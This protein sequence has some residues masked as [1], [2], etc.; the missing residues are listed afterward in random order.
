MENREQPFALTRPPP[1]LP[2]SQW[3]VSALKVPN[4]I[5]TPICPPALYKRPHQPLI[6]ILTARIA[7]LATAPTLRTLNTW[8]FMGYYTNTNPVT[9]AANAQSKIAVSVFL[10]IAGGLSR[11]ESSFANL[12]WLLVAGPP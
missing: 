2:R 4:L 1:L 9:S 3:I 6:Y 7:D 11:T 12:D 10:G 8:S 5:T